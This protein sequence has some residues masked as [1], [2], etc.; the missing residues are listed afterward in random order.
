MKNK[1]AK[2]GWVKDEWVRDGWVK[3]GWVNNG[4]VEECK[5]DNI[6][7]RLKNNLLLL[8]VL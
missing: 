8:Q 4:W 2:D 7:E 5:K 1:W 3:N 6:E